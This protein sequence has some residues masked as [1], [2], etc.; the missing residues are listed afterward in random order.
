MA[1]SLL[2]NLDESKAMVS[3]L[4]TRQKTERLTVVSSI[5]FVTYLGRYLGFSLLQ[6]KVKKIDFTFLIEKTLSGWKGR[7]LNKAGRVTLAKVILSS[8]PVYYMQSLWI[9]QGVCDNIDHIIRSFCGE[10]QI[11]R[12]CIL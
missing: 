3:K 6:G 2:V 9:P 5:L 10:A 12:E 8:M 1:S 4:V 11:G 7:L